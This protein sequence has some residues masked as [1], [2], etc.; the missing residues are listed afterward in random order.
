M[1]MA[2]RG[3]SSLTLALG[4]LAVA[5]SLF[6]AFGAARRRCCCERSPSDRIKLGFFIATSKA[7]RRNESNLYL[8]CSLGSSLSLLFVRGNA[9]Q[10]NTIFDL[11]RD[12][13]C[14]LSTGAICTYVAMGL[15]FVAASLAMFREERE[16]AE[17]GE[18]G[19]SN[20]MENATVPLIQDAVFECEQSVYS[21]RSG[22]SGR[23]VR[24]SQSILLEE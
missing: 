23:S 19:N 2:A 18:T 10:H 15:W 3:F 8:A 11:M 12:H 1:W 17:G 24:S 13:E 9:C 7:I 22:R 16:D 6:A 21:N 20:G 14:K 4:G 5:N